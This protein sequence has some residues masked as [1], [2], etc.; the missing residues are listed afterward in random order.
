MER[1][2]TGTPVGDARL[3][4]RTAL[5]LLGFGA[6]TAV[7]I[8]LAT[9]PPVEREDTTRVV[10]GVADL[11]QVHA[12]FER[13]W[14]RAP[15]A[16]ELSRAFESYVR[17]EVFYR[18]ALARGLDRNDPV[19]RG[20]LVRKIT[21]LGTAQSQALAPTDEE[22]KAYFELRAERY[23]TPARLTVMQ[24][25]LDR[26]K[27]RD[28]LDADVAQLLATLRDEEPGPDALVELGDALMLPNVSR[29]VSEDELAR[30]F[31]EAFREAVVS[32]PIGA[33]Q[34]PVESGYGLHLVLVAQREDSRI[35]DWTTV[36]D[37]IRTD[38]LY[39]GR[40]V[41]EDQFYAEVLPRYQVVYGDGIQEALAGASLSAAVS[42]G[43]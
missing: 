6:L 18:E 11:A 8:L 22:L 35:P 37:R 3:R 5:H 40:S 20:S 26:D 28:S 14:S 43:E 41:A 4:W 17:S 10:F 34:G 7:A 16:I 31:G 42:G 33:W 12:T 9:G 15:T 21:M 30:T 19:V 24:V 23:R 32:L 25:Y 38:L 13:T 36:R 27:H 29:N 39:E 2:A 1:Q